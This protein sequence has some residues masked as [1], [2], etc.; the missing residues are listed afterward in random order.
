MSHAEKLDYDK[1]SRIVW[2]AVFHGGENYEEDKHCLQHH[3]SLDMKTSLTI[4]RMMQA[5]A[6]FKEQVLIQKRGGKTNHNGLRYEYLIYI[7]ISFNYTI[8]MSP[9]HLYRLPIYCQ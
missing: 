4:A 5:V 6:L 1:Q 9:Y 7:H 8:I 2:T 3:S